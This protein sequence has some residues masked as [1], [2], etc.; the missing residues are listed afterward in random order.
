MK[1]NIELGN[2]FAHVFNKEYGII[3]YSGSL[4]IEIALINLNL[5][6][7]SKV[8]VLSEVCYSIINT[9]LKL[10]LKPVIINAKNKLYLTDEDIEIALKKYDISCIMLIHQ[11]GII[12]KINLKK[13]KSQNIKII[14]DVAQVWE[15]KNVGKYSDIVVTSFGK[16]KPLSYGIGGGL[17]TNDTSAINITDF[18]DNDSRG[19]ESIVLSYSYPLCQEMD[20]SKLCLK[21]DTVVNEQKTNAQK[22]YKLL[23]KYDYVKYIDYIDS[24]SWH[25]YPIWFEDGKIYKN[26]IKMIDKTDLEY[27]LEHDI[28]LINLKRNASCIKLN[29]CNNNSN[30]IYLRTRSIDINKQ[31]QILDSV[32]NKI[33]FDINNMV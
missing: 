32:L 16:T 11:Y 25:R 9:I 30:I 17:F 29:N 2:K 7:G 10:G 28:K 19:K 4:A 13:Y 14:E 23:K 26:F 5:K 33:L 6:R 27:Q 20:Y 24:N 8:L 1:D 31:I 12:N 22:Y 3:T 18:Y 15:N 21:A